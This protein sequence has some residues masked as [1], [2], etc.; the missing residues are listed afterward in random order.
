ME[1]TGIKVLRWFFGIAFLVAGL[2]KIF[3]FSGAAGMFE[4]IFGGLGTVLLVI[5]II[6]EVLGGIA[7]L[8]N[9]KA[10]SV[11]LV[12]AL[13]IVVALVVTFKIGSTD[14]IGSLREILVM[15]TGGGNTAVN[16]AYLAGLVAIYLESKN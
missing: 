15:N 12:L 1:G 13:F 5:A 14:F 8:A 7:L 11:S 16:L 6:V 4:G 9:F 2:D 3:H 10:R